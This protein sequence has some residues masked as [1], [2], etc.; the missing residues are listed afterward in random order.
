MPR[1]DANRLSSPFM[2][3]FLAG[4]L[5]LAGCHGSGTTPTQPA[6][7]ENQTTL[8]PETV[9][10]RDSILREKAILTLMRLT[11]D[12]FA[13]IRANA[14]EALSHEPSRAIEVLPIALDDD[15]EGVRAVAAMIV[16][17]QRLVEVA[18]RVRGLVND[19]SPY[20]KSAAI[21]A[22]MRCGRTTNPTPMSDLLLDSPDG[23]VR[24]HVA[25]LLG[26]MDDRS[27]VPLL[28]D[29]ARQRWKDISA[30]QSR[31]LELQIAEALFKLGV[32]EQI[33]SVRASLYPARASDLEATALAVQIVGNVGDHISTRQLIH[34][35]DHRENGQPYPPEVRLTCA[36]ALAKLGQPH[37]GYVADEFADDQ[38]PLLRS[39]A[40]IV[41]GDTGKPETL[42]KLEALLGDRQPVVQ[43]AAASAILRVLGRDRE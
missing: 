27:A 13:S 35:I 31:M 40:A 11:D 34:L 23:R 4:T 20:V 14:I 3:A 6:E 38:N 5:L 41:Y 37:G 22:L 26:E 25:Y 10:L 36:S 16:G 43:V 7:D 18:E 1:I 32:Q 30:A 12:E 21:F 17:Q 9:A 28:R 24:A 8:D 42:P 15:N 29:A 19:P 2:L 39:Q 33:E